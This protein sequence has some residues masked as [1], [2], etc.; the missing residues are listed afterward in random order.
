[1]IFV[2]HKNLNM[3]QL[4]F[5]NTKLCASC[6]KCCCKIHHNRLQESGF[7]TKKEGDFFENA[8]E[9]YGVYPKR[10]PLI[11]PGEYCEFHDLATGCM[12]EREKRPLQCRTSACEKLYIDCEEIHKIYFEEPFRG[13]NPIGFVI[14]ES[15]N[16]LKPSY[17]DE[18]VEEILKTAKERI[19][20]CLSCEHLEERGGF[21]RCKLCGCAL[22]VRIYRKYP[23]DDEGKAIKYI[24]A[25]K[26]LY[27][28]PLKKW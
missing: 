5:I 19:K 24:D 23:L 18:D 12:I 1:M 22:L 28:C 3:I 26:Q 17:E 14:D 11:E 27:A 6:Q 10:N 2:V 13:M 4:E 21:K 25:D 16:Y 20:L 7:V 8:Y 15:T 9:Q